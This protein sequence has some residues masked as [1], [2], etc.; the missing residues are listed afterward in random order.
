MFDSSGKEILQ[1]KLQGSNYQQVSLPT[2]SGGIYF[3]N[4]S[5]LGFNQSIVVAD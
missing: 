2:L 1:I 4:N 3:I 5:E